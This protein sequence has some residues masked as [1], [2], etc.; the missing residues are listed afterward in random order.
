MSTDVRLC[1]AAIRTRSLPG[2]LLCTRTIVFAVLGYNDAE[3]RITTSLAGKVIR[4]R[5]SNAL[6][7][8]IKVLS[9]FPSKEDI[10]SEAR[11]TSTRLTGPGDSAE[12]VGFAR[13]AKRSST[14]KTTVGSDVC[15]QILHHDKVKRV[16]RRPRSGLVIATWTQL[17]DP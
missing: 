8:G 13:S 4:S 12:T 17:T 1:R 15:R 3:T 2:R 9:I 10:S 6:M 7:G 14:A 16:D 11:G 5:R